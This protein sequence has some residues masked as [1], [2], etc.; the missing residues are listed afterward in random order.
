MVCSPN[1]PGEPAVQSGL[2][3]A[4]KLGLIMDFKEIFDRPIA[5]HRAFVGLGC[6]ITGAVMLSQAVYW[7][8]RTGSDGWFYKTRDDWFAET[9]LTR[10][11][12]E[13]ARKKLRDIGVLDE[14]LRGVPA[15]LHYRVNFD[16]IERALSE[17]KPCQQVG[18]KPAIQLAENLPT[19]R[20]KTS[21]QVGGKPANFH[22]EI[23]TET[24]SETTTHARARGAVSDHAA[25]VFEHWKTVMGSPRSR[26]DAKRLKLISARLKDG[27]TPDQLKMAITGCSLSA[28]NMGRN[29][30]NRAFNSVDLIF[31]DAAKVDQF[32]A[33]YETP[34]ESEDD[35]REREIGEWLSGDDGGD[36]FA[37]VQKCRIIEGEVIRE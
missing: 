30:R 7:S 33:M 16:A 31:R 4:C 24:T 27:Y 32:L 26:P 8:K 11:E 6:G 19:R 18:G 9:G 20:R 15:T 22:T 34:P 2:F 17:P 21:Q 3:L 25:S 12:Q 13:G 36:P 14:S 28:W 23:T 1:F 5:Y 37:P 10:S 35:R 29:D